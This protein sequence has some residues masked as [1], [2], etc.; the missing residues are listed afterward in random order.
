MKRIAMAAAVSMLLGAGCST[1][2]PRSA[3]LDPAVT[4][5]CPRSVDSPGALPQLAPFTLED[6]RVVVP[7]DQVRERER[8]ALAAALIFKGAWLEC[9]SVVI[10]AEERARLLN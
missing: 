10:Y 3:A 7:V 8:M 4:A 9:R 1:E 2:R 5:T 6:G